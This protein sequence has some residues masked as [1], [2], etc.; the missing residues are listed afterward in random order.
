MRIYELH[1]I[2]HTF[3]DR[4]V[5]SILDSYHTD[6]MVTAQHDVYIMT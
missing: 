6:D 3:H 1:K 5:F 2:N 4:D